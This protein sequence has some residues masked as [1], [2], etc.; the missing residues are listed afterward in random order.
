MIMKTKLIAIVLS[1]LLCSFITEI[2]TATAAEPNRL[3]EAEKKAGWKLL[4]DGTTTKGWRGYRMEKMP[5]GWQV[6]DGALVR[7]KGGPGGQGA[8]GGHDIVT[9]EEF[10]NFD[11]QLEW[12][13]SP[14]GNSG[15]LYRISEE[16]PAAWHF[17]PEFQL[18]DNTTH[19]NR[20]RRE[21]A[22]ACYDLYAPSKDVT[23][24]VGEWNH[25]RLLVNGPRVEH[26]LN[27]EKV[28]EYELG[29]EDWNR[30][31]AQSK[32]RTRPQF[33]AIKKGPICL[34]DHSDRVEFRSIKIRPLPALD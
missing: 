21:L 2:R 9:T 28:V 13:I 26:W 10:E 34:Q 29:S 25:L 5:P 3:T 30:R 24:P 1:A 33:G 4:F 11:L 20:D 7:V 16:P 23:K 8:G 12:K 22:G 15:V 32:F 6:L 17:A 19:P 31:I 18:L 27:G 14:N